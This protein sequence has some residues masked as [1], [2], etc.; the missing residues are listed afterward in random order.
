[1]HPG[2]LEVKLKEFSSG[3]LVSIRTGSGDITSGIVV[4]NGKSSM[5]DPSSPGKSC[6][7]YSVLVEGD[8]QYVPEDYMTLQE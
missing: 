3:D 4:Y 2:F 6:Y 1:L 8:V 7:V 5:Y